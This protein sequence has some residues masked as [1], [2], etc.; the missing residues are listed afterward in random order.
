MSQA[1]DIETLYDFEGNIEA[2]MQAQFELEQLTAPGKQRDADDIV[3][4]RYAFRFTSSGVFNGHTAI[5]GDGEQRYDMFSGLLD[6][7]TYT[8]RSADQPEDGEQA[9]HAKNRSRLRNALHGFRKRFGPDVMPYYEIADIRELA[10][11]P[12]VKGEE[13]IDETRLSFSVV[14]QIRPGAWPSTL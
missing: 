9:E 4:P 10:S 11:H 3:T 12:T 7:E 14:F 13:D 5:C 6:A 1:P 8:H 2:G